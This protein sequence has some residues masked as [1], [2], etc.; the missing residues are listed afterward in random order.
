[1]QVPRLTVLVWLAV[2]ALAVTA[3]AQTTLDNVKARGKLVCVV[4]TGLAGFAIIG[5]D[6]KWQGFDVDYCRALAAAIFNDTEKVEFRPLT[7]QARFTA[8]QS[9]EIDVLSRNTTWTLSRDTSLGLNFGPP[10]FYDGQG[11]MVPAK[12]GVKSISKLDGAAVCVQTGTT[13]ELNLADYFRR[14]KIKF[15]P[16]VFETTEQTFSAYDS[17]RCDAVTSDISQILAQKTTL[18]DPN[19]HVVLGEVMSKEPLGP[20]VRHGDDQWFDLIKWVAFGVMQAEEFGMT[21]K[22][23]S[24]ATS[25]KDPNV[26]RFLG[27][28][29]GLGEMLGVSNDFMVRVISQVGNYEE[30]FVRNLIP[31]KLERGVNSLWTQG[32][33]LYSPPFR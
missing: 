20:A 28:E 5:P 2:L 15:T 17:G 16:V 11:I 24:E 6:G 29:G 25:N 10:M 9:G 22:N 23:V 27:L 21:S 1:M 13:T 12:L 4:N 26:R 8:L 30:M 14:L 33:L 31:L 19:A 3:S 7:A 32:G 18:K